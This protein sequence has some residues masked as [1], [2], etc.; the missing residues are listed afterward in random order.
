MWIDWVT[1][2]MIQNSYV[3]SIFHKPW[4][5][6]VSF[7]LKYIFRLA[8]VLFKVMDVLFKIMDVR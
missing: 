2:Q 6:H 4:D 5:F 3:I 8:N 7:P 1:T